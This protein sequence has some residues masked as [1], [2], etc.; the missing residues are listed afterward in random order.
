MEKS[1]KE[2]WEHHYAS[3]DFAKLPWETNRPEE[4]LVR[5]IKQGKIER[6]KALDLGCGSGTHAIYLARLGFDVTGLDISK[7][8]I[9]IAKERARKEGV[10]AKFLVGNALDLKFGSKSFDFVFDRGC[11]HH[12]PI[13]LRERYV[14][15]AHS[16]LRNNGKY[17][18]ICFSDR[19]NWKQEREEGKLFSMEK[20]NSNFSKYFE[21]QEAREVVHI[22]PNDGESVYLRSVLMSKK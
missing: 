11:F 18:L 14:Q 21:I 20:I 7:S 16:L 5:L 19:N 10:G 3:G 17:H 4:E 2:I 13:D 12:L 8:A 22:Q 1:T 9:R 15:G 6:G